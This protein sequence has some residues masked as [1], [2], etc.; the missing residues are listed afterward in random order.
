MVFMMS[1]ILAMGLQAHVVAVTDYGN[2]Y[3]KKATLEDQTGNVKNNYG[4]DEQM[5]SKYEFEFPDNV[6]IE[7][8]NT[9]TMFLP[10]QLKIGKASSFLIKDSAGEKIAEVET[11]ATAKKILITFSNYYEIHKKNRSMSFKLYTNWD[12]SVVIGGTNVTV[13]FGMFQQKVYIE[14]I[15]AIDS[16]EM[17]AQWGE[18]DQEDPTL[19]HW[20]TRLNFKGVNICKALYHN[21]IGDQQSLVSKSI[22]AYIGKFDQYGTF[23]EQE[24]IDP[25][26]I[27]E[28]D[29][30]KYFDIDIHS[31]A[32]GILVRYDTRVLVENSSYMRYWTKGHLV[33][34]HHYFDTIG[35]SSVEGGQGEGSGER[36]SEYQL[37]ISKYDQANPGIKLQGAE[38]KL[39]DAAGKT[40]AK[41]IVTDTH[42]NA[43]IMNLETGEY[44]LIETAAPKGYQSAQKPVAVSISQDQPK[45]IE[46][47]VANQKK[48]GSV[49]LTKLDE[50]NHRALPNA[51]F[52]LKDNQ[53]NT[54][55]KDLKTDKDGQLSVYNLSNGSYKFVET[56]APDDYQIDTTPLNFKIDTSRSETVELTKTNKPKDKVTPPTPIP[57]TKP[58]PK[59]IPKKQV[60]S[61]YLEKTDQQTGQPL[62]GAIFKLEDEKGV[63]L[64][65]GLI[66]NDTGKI[67]IHHLAVGRYQLVETM[68]P[69]GYVLDTA[70]VC[71]SIT[72][73]KSSVKL[74]KS[75]RPAKRSVILEK[76]DRQTGKVLPGAIFNLKNSKGKVIQ[77]N[78]ET[79]Q[80]GQIILDNLSSGK[81]E[82]SEAK[83]PKGYQLDSTPVSFQ[84]TTKSSGTIRLLKT[85]QAIKGSVILTGRDSETGLPLVEGS[86]YLKKKSGEVIEKN[87]K[88]DTN[89]QLVVKEL[90]PGEYE[91]IEN[92]APEGYEKSAKPTNFTIAE[93]E[94]KQINVEIANKPLKGSV[95]LTKVDN[96]TGEHLANAVFSLKTKAGKIVKKNLVTN[97][98]GTLTIEE[99]APGEY[100]LVEVKAPK[101]YKIDRTPV[102]F[103]VKKA[104]K[105]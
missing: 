76:K 96:K 70:P 18:F 59:P 28:E 87:L 25:V 3:L 46:I 16:N 61:V 26:F 66:T 98:N 13:N 10:P 65:E 52:E 85:N 57:D 74:S 48:R 97:R 27:H 33:S 12:H 22:Q 20:K 101:G 6:R 7:A 45:E 89:G 23:Q 102:F 94:A 103:E 43:E 78:L 32:T 29:K 62:A 36:T 86:F 30:E 72:T 19:I 4:Y 38:F 53:G 75:N 77:K 68:A 49:H 17:I 73:K 42:G 9:M 31:L 24:T 56:A 95:S 88:L 54:L 99:L 34:H 40:V 90:M 82:L 55:Q 84:V 2:Q 47:P 35:Y 63:T 58:V 80:N 11:D 83:A 1:I 91:F 44:Q 50:K 69:P 5:Q 79:N 8:G 21:E 93:N 37:K 71:F 64:Q 41:H 67:A 60:G 14:P 105:K 15:K 39:V 51:I 100:Q 81:Y 92:K 104:K